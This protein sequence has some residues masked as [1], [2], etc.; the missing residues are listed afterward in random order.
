MALKDVLLIFDNEK[1]QLLVSSLYYLKEDDDEQQEPP[2]GVCCKRGKLPLGK[3]LP[4][5]QLLIVCCPSC[6]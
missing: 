1:C 6:G 4:L 2:Y 5:P 3:K